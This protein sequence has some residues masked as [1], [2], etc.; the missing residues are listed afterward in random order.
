MDFRSFQFTPAVILIFHLVTAMV[1]AHMEMS[2]PY[3]LRS[4][5]DPANHGTN[6]IDYSNTAPLAP[7]GSQFPCK[8]YLSG[9]THVVATLAAPGQYNVSLAGTA[10]HNGGSCQLSLSNNNGSTFHVIESY[11]GNCPTGPN[12]VLDYT[13]P[14]YIPP[15]QY[16]FAWTWLNHVGNREFYMNCAIMTITSAATSPTDASEFA[17][18]PGIYVANQHGIN[19]C[20]TIEGVDPCFPDP[21]P[22]VV[23]GADMQGCTPSPASCEV[24]A[25]RAGYGSTASASPTVSVDSEAR[26]DSV[27]STSSSADPGMGSVSSLPTD[28]LSSSVHPPASSSD[29]PTSSTT[30]M[31]TECA[32]ASDMTLTFTTTSQTTMTVCPACSPNTFMTVTVTTTASCTSSLPSTVSMP[33]SSTAPPTSI[34][35]GP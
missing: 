7:D 32:T 6:Y 28:P 25:P 12:S 26:T 15:G 11:I 13:L 3:T 34:S 23:Y 22:A 10:F 14:S 27:S 8:G 21:G 19:S 30:D 24:P 5:F 18:L 33:T 17:A 1:T 20:T 2:W 9:S 4:K 31:D 16:V 29:P 35:T